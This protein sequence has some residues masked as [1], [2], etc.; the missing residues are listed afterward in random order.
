MFMICNFR[1]YFNCLMEKLK[2]IIFFFFIHS[3]IFVPDLSLG[4]V[5]ALGCLKV[6]HGEQHSHIVLQ[7][8]H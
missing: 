3:L 5:A 2:L 1:N 7:A 4:W 6:P 8:P